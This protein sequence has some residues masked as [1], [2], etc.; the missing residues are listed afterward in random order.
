MT[1]LGFV[2]AG[3]EKNIEGSAYAIVTG[4]NAAAPAAT[5]ILRIEFRDP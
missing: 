5:E 4:D 3:Q 2:V 1:A